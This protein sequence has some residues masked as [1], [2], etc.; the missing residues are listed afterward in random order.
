ML[1]GLR[2][3]LA[4]LPIGDGL[5]DQGVLDPA[6]QLRRR[7]DQGWVGDCRRPTGIICPNGHIDFGPHTGQSRT[8]PARPQS[9][10]RPVAFVVTM[11]E[12]V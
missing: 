10:R 4:H 6:G 3:V 11:P 7:Q 1:Q 2:D 12:V 9:D 8:G 5:P